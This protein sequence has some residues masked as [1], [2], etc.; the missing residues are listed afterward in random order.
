MKKL[1]KHT[2]GY[3]IYNKNSSASVPSENR[4]E[5]Y[6]GDFRLGKPIL[7][8]LE[9]I[10]GADHLWVDY[11]Y[12]DKPRYN[13]PSRRDL[14]S[15]ILSLMLA[16]GNYPHKEIWIAAYQIILKVSI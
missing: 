6:T 1:Q 10:Q 2:Q 11:T 13:F 8:E 7:D 4:K 5:V 15:E 9:L 12:G 14:I 3:S 16:D